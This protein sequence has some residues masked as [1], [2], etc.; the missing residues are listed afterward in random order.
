MNTKLYTT[1]EEGTGHIV[2]T[3]SYRI[4]VGD[5][6]YLKAGERIPVDMVVL[7][8]SSEGLCYMETAPLDGETN[9][10]QVKAVMATMSKSAEELAQMRG[11]VECETPHHRLYS[12]RGNMAIQGLEE[13]VSLDE[14][15]LLLMGSVLKNTEWVIGL[16]VYAGPETKMGLN[17]KTPPSKFSRLD[18]GLN[19]YVFFIF[20]VNF[21]ICAL[22]AGLSAWWNTTEAAKAQDLLPEF[23]TALAVIASFLSY[24]ALLNYMIPLSMVITLE[25]A[26]FLQAKFM[27]WDRNMFHDGRHCVAKTSNLNDEL[28]LVEYI[29]SDKTGTLTENLMTFRECSVNGVIYKDSDFDTN[30]NASGGL[31][32]TLNHSHSEKEKMALNK[33][34]MGLA[35]CHS[36]QAETNEKTGE[37]EY[38]AASPDEEALCKGAKENGFVYLD[39]I[40]NVMKLKILD[41]EVV[42]EI[43]LEI[44]FTSERRRMTMVLRDEQGVIT[45]FCKGADSVILERLDPHS[46]ANI[47]YLDS[48]KS[49]LDKFSQVGLRT[50]LFG[51]KAIT[52][53]EWEE[54]RSRWAAS[55]T[56][57]EGRDEALEELADELEN[58]LVL[59]GAGAIEDKLQDGVP[60]TIANLRKAGIKIWVITGDKQ[61][62]AINIGYSSKLL[63]PSME[64]LTI[65][66]TDEEELEAM[67]MTH[68]N[69]WVKVDEDDRRIMEE[70][71]KNRDEF[72][73]KTRAMLTMGSTVTTNTL[74]PV[75][76]LQSQAPRAKMKAAKGNHMKR[77]LK[78]KKKP[79][80]LEPG[81]GI[82][83]SEVSD[84]MTF[85][86]GDIFEGG[87]VGGNGGMGGDDAD[88]GS[89]RPTSASY[90]SDVALQMGAS[91]QVKLRADRDSSVSFGSSSASTSTS[92]YYAEPTMLRSAS[93]STSSYGSMMDGADA[94]PN[95]PALSGSFRNDDSFRSTLGD[96]FRYQSTRSSKKKI[97]IV[98][99]GKTLVHILLN[100]REIFMILA[101]NAMSVVCNR[102]TPLQKA[103]LVKLVSQSEGIISLAIGDGGNDVSMIQQAH[104]GVGIQGREGNQAARASDFALPQ[105][106][107]LQRL[108]TIHGR[109]CLLRN[110]KI[111][112]YSIY[113]NT[114]TFFPQFYYG[115][116]NGFSAQSLYNQWVMMI[117]NVFLTS[118]P[119][120]FLGLFE[121]DLHESIIE[122]NPQVYQVHKTLKFSSLFRW[123]AYAIYHATVIFW[124]TFGTFYPTTTVTQT[125]RDVGSQD[126]GFYMMTMAVLVVTLRLALESVHWVVF[127]HFA[128]W[129]SLVFYFLARL[130]LSNMLEF[131][132]GQYGIFELGLQTPTFWLSVI[133]VVIACLLPNFAVKYLKRSYYPKEWYVLQEKNRGRG[134]SHGT[135]IFGFMG[136]ASDLEDLPDDDHYTDDYLEHNDEKKPLIRLQESDIEH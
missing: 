85:Q 78:K 133:L 40:Q 43:L 124:F 3:L 24:F 13:V 102:V 67:L 74:Q 1:I 92:S 25:V 72:L 42:Y 32:R 29:F 126:M 127:T 96:S 116:F 82:S 62:T 53:S 117:F 100:F 33:F 86:D 106:R 101:R 68:I 77:K 19:T 46:E 108:L 49:H 4:R 31:L 110:T 76:T 54:F 41:Q 115:F 39:R 16:C 20:G 83:D 90:S 118:V 114:A 17:L 48:T 84:L 95:T 120:F 99:D 37:L 93:S 38:K 64:V 52:S 98:V 131:D 73:E 60:E 75:N 57:I 122:Q 12:F 69:Q 6:V 45:M 47:K 55:A 28:A 63:T 59:I 10:K 56:L 8:T 129:G 14:K 61:E 94:P 11:T 91:P 66:S 21:F 136:S 80:S 36:V 22:M 111:I 23:P 97:A 26:R 130:A 7:S 104:I 30:P 58:G 9:L 132:T 81:G 112:Y 105:F 123:F 88:D 34:L 119:I 5:L 18:V 50:L 71:R 27:S 103:E 15:N 125:G 128:V 2:D 107:H 79:I 134:L 121:K 89:S 65:N 109:F 70:W 113:K 51:T 35:V 44:E 87:G 135:S